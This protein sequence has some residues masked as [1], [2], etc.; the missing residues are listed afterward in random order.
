MLFYIFCTCLDF[1]FLFVFD[2]FSDS[3]RFSASVP[4][5]FTPEDALGANFG[6]KKNKVKRGV[7]SNRSAGPNVRAFQNS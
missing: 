7:D 1:M 6:T 3:S 4:P 5:I 2:G